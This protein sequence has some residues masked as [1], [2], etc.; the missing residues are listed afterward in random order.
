MPQKQKIDIA[1]V[2]EDQKLGG[3][4]VK[5]VIL[6]MLIMCFDGYDF[7]G[8][9]FAAPYMARSWSIPPSSFG[10]VFAIG[11][12]G[13]LIGGISFGFVGDL[14]GRKPA[15][16]LSALCFSLP[17]LLTV[18]C[19][20]VS[21]LFVIRL[22][23]GIGLG[24]LFPLGLVLC[25]EFVPRGYRATVA[26]IANA[27]YV[28]GASL[29]GVVAKALIPSYGWPIIFWIGGVGPILLCLLLAAMLPESVRFLAV[30]KRQPAAIARILRSLKPGIA[31]A[32]DAEFFVSDDEKRIGTEGPR[33]FRLSQLF[34][35]RLAWMTSLLW[36]CYVAS[37]STV[38]F[39]TSWGPTVVE[40]LGVSP[41]SASIATS[42][43]SIGGLVATL[44]MARF[45][46]R[47]G[48]I[49][50]AVLPLIACPLIFALGRVSMSESMY[51]AAMCAIGFFVI[52]T[53][54]SL[55][56]V[57]G[58][59]YP[60]AY[61]ANGAGWALSVSRLGSIGGPLVG[62]LMLAAHMPLS[63]VFLFVAMP[64]IVL[65][66]GL[67]SLGIFHRQLLAE[68]AAFDAAAGP[69]RG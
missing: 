14:L 52:G 23:S 1:R 49:V 43:F 64:P 39:I 30:T 32:A 33:T 50:I 10:P 17:T 41:G 18:F 42:L 44:C 57:A 61:R 60:S 12:F 59:Y 53:H 3:F 45:I 2:L 13:L 28:L 19:T 67:Y 66:I 5:L 51:M 4:A 69:S 54:G 29:G 65:A 48:A 20:D 25:L 47:Y 6:T 31:V 37:S 15:I 35:G 7:N 21:Q 9:G 24:G 56:S 26:V 22:I 40:A 27:G 34:K 8:M 63:E 55:H 11:S 68:E 38:F 58:I 36:L 46:D 16:I 62:G